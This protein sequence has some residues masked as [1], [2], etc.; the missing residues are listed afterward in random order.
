MRAGADFQREQEP[1][2][3]D[4]AARRMDDDR[5]ADAGAFRVQRLLHDER[6]RVAAVRQDRTVAAAREPEVELR[7]PSARRRGQ[8]D[9]RRRG[10]GVRGAVHSPAIAARGAHF[11]ASADA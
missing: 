11:K 9:V 8:R 3:A 10:A 1:V 2:A 5:L 6:T 7:L 4:D